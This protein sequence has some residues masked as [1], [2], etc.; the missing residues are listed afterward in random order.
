MVLAT[1]N[2]ESRLISTL[3]RLG[4][5]EINTLELAGLEKGKPLQVHDDVSKEL[6]RVRSLITAFGT[7][8]LP[9]KEYGEIKIAEPEYIKALQAASA[10]N[11]DTDLTRL[12]KTRGE[13]SAQVKELE[14]KLTE[15]SKIAPFAGVDFSNLETKTFT[16]TLGTVKTAIFKKFKKD[17]EEYLVGSV[18]ILEAHISKEDVAIL[19]FYPR[20][21]NIEFILSR[22]NFEKILL[23][24]NFSTF[25]KGIAYIEA[26]LA[27]TKQRIVQTE[28]ELE[29]LRDRYMPSLLKLEKE[30]SILSSRASI[31]AKFSS[32]RRIIAI[33]GWVKKSDVNGLEQHLKSNF[34]DEVELLKYET[35]EGAPIV[36]DNPKNLNQFQWL[37]EFYSLPTYNE[38]DP[39]FI[40]LFTVP[41]MYGMIVGDVGYGLMSAVLSLLILSKFKEG[42]LGNVAKIWLFSSI[43]AMVFG[44]VFDEWFGFTHFGLIELLRKWGINTGITHPLY[45][46]IG[47]GEHLSLV[48]GLSLITGVLHLSLGFILGAINEWNHDKKH[49][50]AKIMWLFLLIS[51]TL[52]ISSIMFNLIPSQFGIAAGA[53]FIIS[54]IIV[55]G[56]EGLPGLFEIPG[57]TANVLSYARIAAAGVVGVIIA[58]IINESMIPIPEKSILLLPVFLFLHVINAALAMFESI[59]QGG[60]LNLVEFYSKFYH[61][62]GRAFEPFS[63]KA[64]T[65][66]SSFVDSQAVGESKSN[67]EKK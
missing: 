10:I 4:V 54:S 61:G 63:L 13:L 41:L 33:S 47:R 12:L 29:E 25:E 24:E 57:L 62:G 65:E 21:E 34:K 22:Y 1:K 16:F 9:K 3:H 19:V 31:A 66:S 49:A 32:G 55:I 44:L 48:I 46:G 35:E 17:L 18:Y 23:P 39:T 67:K 38:L 59:V 60:R 37:V 6:V 2:S 43:S 11:I 58:E 7:A 50:L 5:M 53:I 27:D 14:K 20:K 64:S 26:A 40:L 30:L 42:M 36:L 56:I 51:G 8:G 28:K 52:S 15:I 45:T